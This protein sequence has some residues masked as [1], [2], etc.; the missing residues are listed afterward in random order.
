MDTGTITLNLAAVG[1]NFHISNLIGIASSGRHMVFNSAGDVYYDTSTARFKQNITLAEED[2]FAVLTLS[3]KQWNAREGH[4]D[5]TELMT[6]FIAEEVVDALP[7][8]R[9]EDE[10]GRVANYDERTVVASML[11]VIKDQQRR[12]EELEARV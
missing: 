8:A 4:G 10:Y 9:I 1:S 5:T 11:E 7:S 12:I 6:G 2:P 3:K